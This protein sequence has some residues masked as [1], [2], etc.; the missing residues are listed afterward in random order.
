MQGGQAIAAG[1]L[2]TA[3]SLSNMLTG[4]ASAYGNQQNF[5]TMMGMMGNQNNPYGTGGVPTT[6]G[7]YQG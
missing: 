5:N 2:G 4:G 1:Q 3:N 6:V 7:S